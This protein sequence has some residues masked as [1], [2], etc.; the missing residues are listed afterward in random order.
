MEKSSKYEVFEYEPG[1]F[2]GVWQKI[3]HI[4]LKIVGMCIDYSVEFYRLPLILRSFCS[5]LR[6]W[7][8]T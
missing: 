5:R 4:R 2:A 1:I 6:A 8:R 7:I 3:M